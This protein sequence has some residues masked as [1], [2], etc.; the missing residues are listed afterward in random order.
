[1]SVSRTEKVLPASVFEGV[2]MNALMR[3]RVGLGLFSLLITW[4]GLATGGESLMGK[5]FASISMEH[6]KNRAYKAELQML[7]SAPLSGAS[8]SKAYSSHVLFYESDGLKQYLLMNRPESRVPEKGFPVLIFGHGFHPEPKKHGLNKSTGL[9]HRPGDYYRGIPEIFAEQGFVVLA[10][11]YRGHGESEGY[12]YT[13]RSYLS[14]AYYAIDVLHLL[15]A[16]PGLEDV[17]QRNVF[18]LG[19]SMG[20][21]VGLR[22][23]LSGEGKVKAASLWSPE[24]ASTYE[25]AL[26]YGR[27]RSQN[28]LVTPQVMRSYLDEIG[29]LYGADAS[30]KWWAEELASQLELI[31]P[32]NFVEELSIPVILQ[33]AEADQEVPF[34]WSE[35]LAS[36]L[37]AAGID[38]EFYAYPTDNHL[39]KGDNFKLAIARDLVFFRGRMSP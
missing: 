23:I 13:R 12:E 6:L 37:A 15:A 35:R 5:N 19:H 38:F 33:H 3:E 25:K 36:K 28:E 4:P 32:I 7:G 20:G 9:M 22:T 14:A 16:L 10:P 39:F 8:G 30:S 2:V 1:M 17:D 24:V 18:Y 31:D 21:D 26:H 29:H 11:D 34:L 27:R